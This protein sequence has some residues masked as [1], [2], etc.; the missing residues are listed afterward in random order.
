MRALLD[1]YIQAEPSE[2][3]ATFKKGLVE[4]VVERG[5]GALDTLPPNI[6]KNH[7][8]GGDDRQQCSQDHRR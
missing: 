7:D 5:E 6:R 8:R 2:V 3:V 1:T 4:L